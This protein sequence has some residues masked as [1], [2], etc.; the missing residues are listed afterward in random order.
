MVWG[1]AEHLDYFQNSG[2]SS[3]HRFLPSDHLFVWPANRLLG[4]LKQ[5]M[6]GRNGA[7]G[8]GKLLLMFLYY[9]SSCIIIYT[10]PST[11]GMH[12]LD[13]VSN[14]L[15]LDLVTGMPADRNKHWCGQCANTQINSKN[16]LSIKL[17][18][19]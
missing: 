4:I 2:I 19:S 14:S 10:R 17:I 6:Q 11:V 8:Q 1:G 16:K 18:R 15:P 13:F 7:F 5:Y 9:C 3:N 12:R